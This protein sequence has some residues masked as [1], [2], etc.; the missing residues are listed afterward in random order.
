MR[1]AVEGAA[2][3]GVENWAPDGVGPMDG[4]EIDVGT[5]GVEPPD[6]GETD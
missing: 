4:G 2:G 6:T 1:D 5:P 3:L